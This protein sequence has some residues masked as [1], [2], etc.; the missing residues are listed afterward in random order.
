M[1]S[2]P[3][4]EQQKQSEMQSVPISEEGST[5]F[6]SAGEETL[7]DN[8]EDPSVDVLAKRCVN[9]CRANGIENPVEIL[10][11]AQSVIVSG[12]PL[13]VQDVSQSLEGET[14]FILINRQDVLKSAMDEVQ[15]LKDPRLTLSVGFYGECA[16]DYGGPRK[17]FF[18]LCLRY[19]KATYFDNGLKDH[20]T[21]DYSTIVLIMALSTLQNGSIP[22]F[23]KKDNLQALL[24]YVFNSQVVY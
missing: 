3:V 19:I 16:E 20:L 4:S 8:T 6:Q 12:R 23:V 7:A 2:Q 15:F 9:Y 11:Y 18:R 24:K 5:G 10:R 13:D 1:L 22:R 14:N 21:N 17:E